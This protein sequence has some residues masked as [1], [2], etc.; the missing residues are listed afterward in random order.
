[1][2]V[3]VLFTDLPH[4]LKALKPGR[5]L[6]ADLGATLEVLVVRALPY[7]APLTCCGQE[8]FFQHLREGLAGTGQEISIKVY[9]C[10][11]SFEYPP[12]SPAT[13]SPGG[14]RVAP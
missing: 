7:P 10:R 14:C 9:L 6:A 4:T 1:M 3:I 2:H 11:G 5:S 8:A 13:E 12:S